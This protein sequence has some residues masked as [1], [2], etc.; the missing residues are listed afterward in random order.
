[1]KKHLFYGISLL[2]SILVN[3]I[4]M[5]NGIFNITQ[6]LY[7]LPILLGVF[8][9][10]KAGVYLASFT[11]A[12][13][14]LTVLI[15]D[16]SS[17][18]I[19]PVVIRC[20][21]FIF[22]AVLVYSLT[23]RINRQERKLREEHKWLET[24]LLSI[25]DGVVAADSHGLIQ[26]VNRE[27]ELITGLCLKEVSG[28]KFA[29]V[30][31]IY[32]ASNGGKPEKRY[33]PP[34]N[35]DHNARTSDEVVYILPDGS[36]K[37]LDIKTAPILLPDRG[38]LGSVVVFRDITEKKRIE[39][40]N[41]YLTYHDKLT[42]LYN[43]RFFEEELRRLDVERSLPV[44]IIIGDVNG[45]KLTNDAFG[46][47]AGDNLLITAGK[48]MQ[49]VC[50]DSDI[51]ARWGG[52]EYIILLPNTGLADAEQISER[53]RLKCSETSVNN[54]VLSISLGCAAKNS[55]KEDLFAVIKQADDLMYRKKLL[56]SR[57]VKSRAVQSV[58]NTL[59]ESNP[60]EEAHSLRVGKLCEKLGEALQIDKNGISDLVLLAAVHDIGKASIDSSVLNK[61]GKLTAEEYE[62]IKQH[63][64][65]G[66]HII[67][68]SPDF[69]YL[70]N[71]VL[72]HH[73]R[74][75]GAGYP[76]GLKGEDI[77]YLSRILSVADAFEAM[78][79]EKPYRRAFS[80]EEALAELK[81]CAGTQFD[82]EIVDAFLKIV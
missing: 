81:S 67:S 13:Y 34:F 65:K 31:P 45:L 70:A 16:S 18:S 38:S 49:E 82:P 60:K 35:D 10:N 56:E 28:K 20:F 78:T 29:E 14:L 68:A 2:C 77:P 15:F 71:Y 33:D 24:T 27:A 39:K 47:L 6:H 21:I 69:S 36:Q 43:R 4:F 73:E 44:S 8:Y 42:G 61:P 40:E 53:I 22:I 17:Q 12:L 11:S 72:A 23:E 19:I 37:E 9:Y 64:E 80:K 74:W 7:Y 48:V 25:G 52:D 66:Y 32:L 26:T 51:V 5:K 63:S 79:S 3:M 59:H 41:V 50:R 55:A 76:S 30:Y 54:I 46:H 58:L 62:I 57:S 75:D 1:M